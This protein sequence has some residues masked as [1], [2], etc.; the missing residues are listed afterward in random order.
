M[1][2]CDSSAA[3]WF[4]S[5]SFLQQLI[6]QEH[7]GLRGG[8]AVKRATAC[9]SK[10]CSGVPSKRHS[11]SSGLLKCLDELRESGSS[12]VQLWAQLRGRKPPPDRNQRRRRSDLRP[13]FITFT[14]GWHGWSDGCVLFML[15]AVRVC[16]VKLK[17][18]KNMFDSKIHLM[19]FEGAR[20]GSLFSPAAGIVCLRSWERLSSSGSAVTGVWSVNSSVGSSGVLLC[21]SFCQTS[22]NRFQ[23]INPFGKIRNRKKTVVYF[24]ARNRLKNVTN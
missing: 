21:D 6:L 13:A 7:M 5:I 14:S 4:L 22:G 15:R 12:G 11:D 8:G 17:T 18:L 2:S 19:M 23:I 16:E 10:A 24:R 9:C 1:T 3:L 20:T